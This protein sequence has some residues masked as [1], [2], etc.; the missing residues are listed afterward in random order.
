MAE[1]TDNLMLDQKRD[2]GLIVALLGITQSSAATHL[3]Q[4]DVEVRLELLEGY[5]SECRRRNYLLQHYS[6]SLKE[7]TYFKTDMYK[8]SLEKYLSAKAWF[9]RRIRELSLPAAAPST[10]S[11]QLIMPPSD[12]SSTQ[13][14]LEKLKL[15]HFNG[16]QRQWET[17]K[18]KFTALIIN[19]GRM[20]PIIKIQHLANCL[21]VE[22]AEK[23][24]GIKCVGVNFQTAWEA[25]CKRYDN[26]YLRF[27]VQMET[28]ENMSS[29]ASQQVKHLCHLIN[30]VDESIHTFTALQRKYE[31]WDDIYIYFVETKLPESTRQD[32]TKQKESKNLIA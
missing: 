18:D 20:N 7:S 29:A 26:T 2:A 15:P 13:A 32:W 21:G 19:D 3:S 11:G 1:S 5:W 22:P 23:L 12:V 4:D 6:D 31:N 25:L 30:I 14:S 28:L 27:A 17:F 8:S 9:N 24:R 16:D 10:G